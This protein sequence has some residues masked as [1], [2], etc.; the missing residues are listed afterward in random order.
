MNLE[1]S[2]YLP[3]FHGIERYEARPGC[4]ARLKQAI[5]RSPI[6]ALLGPRQSG[7]TTLARMISEEREGTLLEFGFEFISA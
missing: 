5:A 2:D 7:K 3:I 4:I 1:I 6:T